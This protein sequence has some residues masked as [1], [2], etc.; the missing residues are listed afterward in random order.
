MP[1]ETQREEKPAI[2]D[3]ERVLVR[4]E[5]DDLEGVLDNPHRHLL[6]AGVPAVHHHGAD[7][8]LHDWAKRLAEAPTLTC[9]D[10]NSSKSTNFSAS[11]L[12]L[13]RSRRDKA[14]GALL[15]NVHFRDKII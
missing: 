13:E 12:S 11:R 10:H 1:L 15:K 4:Q 6:L 3:L 8:A 9:F 14:V 5:V 2:E 7:K